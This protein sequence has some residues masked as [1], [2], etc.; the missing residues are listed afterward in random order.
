M[1]NPTT[2][3]HKPTVPGSVLA[4]G[5][6]IVAVAL[7]ID[8]AAQWQALLVEVAGLLLV[9]GG[10]GAWNQQ[11]R[12]AGLLSA[13][14]GVLL[15]GVG[16]VFAVSIPTATVHRLELLPGMLGLIA[17]LAGLLPIRSDWE[18]ELVSVG[19]ALLFIGVATSGV[20]RESTLVSLLLAGIATVVAWDLG[21]Q[22]VSMGRQ[23][24]RGARTYRAELT[25]AAGTV[26]AGVG[27]LVATL[28]V[29]RLDVQGLS[30]TSLSVLLL[31]GFL[32]AVSIRQ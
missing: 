4:V 8:T 16:I 6:G 3:T 7:V 19:A 1:T 15:I 18:R 2:P 5:T 27:A 31:A 12:I 32:L 28:G 25:H 10:Y 26:F 17:L 21:E 14:A 29:N 9:A 22:A 11:R 30:L 13:I 24:G 23:L 20:V